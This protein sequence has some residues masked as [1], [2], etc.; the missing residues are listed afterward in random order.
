MFLSVAIWKLIKCIFPEKDE[1][2]D[3]FSSLSNIFFLWSFYDKSNF[4]IETN[5]YIKKSTKS[6]IYRKQSLW[7][8]SFKSFLI[9]GENVGIMSGKV[10]C[11]YHQQNSHLHFSALKCF[12]I[13]QKS[14]NLLFQFQLLKS[15]LISE[16]FSVV[17]ENGL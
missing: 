9:V 7:L 17:D 12:E 11:Q 14:K 8:L 2:W 1:L 10:F 4:K 3:F 16:C 5:A 15:F 13:F 6:K